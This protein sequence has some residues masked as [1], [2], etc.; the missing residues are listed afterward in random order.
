M[1]Y[2]LR[3]QESSTFFHVYS[4]GA[5]RQDIYSLEGDQ[6]LFESIVGDG[7][8]TALA[9]LYIAVRYIHRNPLAFIPVRSLAAYSYSSLGVYLAR[10]P[11]PSWL[12]TEVVAPMVDSAT[13]LSEVVEVDYRDIVPWGDVPAL[14][15][16]SLG[17]LASALEVVWPDGWVAD[18]S[19]R[20]L[21]M[22]LALE[23]RVDRLDDVAA[24][25]GVGPSAIRKAARR[26]RV[27]LINDPQFAARR[28]DVLERLAR[29]TSGHPVCNRQER[30]G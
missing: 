22:T 6:R 27:R 30:A 3:D 18:R 25:F 9:H 24:F 20:L 14:I 15:Q 21:G 19:A 26:G 28:V 11:A 7:E 29:G 12:T 2:A 13:Y 8:S 16:R 10:R 17:A 23:L 4:R 1:P 5:D